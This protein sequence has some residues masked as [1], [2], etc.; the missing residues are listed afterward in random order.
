VSEYCEEHRGTG[1]DPACGFC[2]I[3]MRRLDARSPA[4]N[5]DRHAGPA[6]HGLEPFNRECVHCR[7]DAAIYWA[8]Q[9][10]KKRKA[11][12]ARFRRKMRLLE[13]EQAQADEESAARRAQA[14]GPGAPGYVVWTE[15]TGPQTTRP[16]EFIPEAHC[17]VSLDRVSTYQVRESESW[18]QASPVTNDRVLDLVDQIAL[19]WANVL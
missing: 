14:V 5:H 4:D 6:K 11:A 9:E 1:F 18:W 8:Q 16:R 12:G 13:R 15:D 19:G 3:D 17:F 7:I 10:V 2:R